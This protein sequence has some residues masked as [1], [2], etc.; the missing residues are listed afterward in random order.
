MG[1]DRFNTSVQFPNRET[2]ENLKSLSV[3][4][5]KPIGQVIEAMVRKEMN[6]QAILGVAAKQAEVQPAVA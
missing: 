2:Y 4:Q 1:S 3:Q 5:D 6:R